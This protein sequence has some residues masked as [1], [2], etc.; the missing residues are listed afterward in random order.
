MVKDD[1]AWVK[2]NI[3][4]KGK[5]DIPNNFVQTAPVYTG[6]DI[7]NVSQQKQ[8]PKYKNPQTE[9]FLRMLDVPNK[10]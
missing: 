2:E 7:H 6:A 5:L 3:V 9:Q 1:Y 4:D 8:L 10:L